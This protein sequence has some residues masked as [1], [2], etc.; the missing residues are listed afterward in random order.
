M[1]P[2]LFIAHR[3]ES[4]DAPE[5]T[6]AS[7]DL[8]WQRGDDAVEFDVHITA[9]DRVVL[10][11]DADTGRTGDRSLVI[12][13]HTLADL[14]Q[15]DIGRWKG[16]QWIG[17]SVPT[18]E[19]ILLQT[20]VNKRLFVEIKPNTPIAADAVARILVMKQWTSTNV[21]VI[22]FHLNVLRTMT[23]QCPTRKFFWLLENPQDIESL[24]RT[25]H[26]ERLDGLDLKDGPWLNAALVQT[27]RNAGLEKYVWTVDDPKRCKHLAAMGVDGITTNRAAWITQ[28]CR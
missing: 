11:H 20:P 18:L 5:N 17:Q 15:V 26:A 10:C 12:R 4:F 21:S 7:I 23:L 8:A 6:L 13:E 28:L 14:Q 22:S 9:D 24:V 16:P 2:S 27:L 3:G 25:A 1:T 19:Q